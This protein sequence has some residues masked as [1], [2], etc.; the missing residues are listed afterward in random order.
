MV[1]ELDVR[2]TSGA[3]VVSPA[4][5]QWRL[6]I[7]G[8]QGGGYRLAQLDD[9]ST[10]PRTRFRWYPPVSLELRARVSA[11]DLPGTW[12]FGLWNDPFTASLGMAGTARRLP[13]LPEAAWFFCAS[14][15]NYLALHDTHP[16]QGLLAATFA[17]RRISAPLLAVALPALP[18]LAWSLTAR[19]L[20]MAARRFVVEDALLLDL[21]P[22][23]WH[24]YR[25]DW[26]RDAVSFAVDGE[27][28]FS[29]P[30]APRAPLGLVLWIDNQYAAFPPDGRLRFG[31]LPNPLAWLELADL[32]IQ[33]TFP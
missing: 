16:A 26:C 1:P 20:R 4:S 33:K 12:G 30:V 8:G 19:W 24:S 9:Y 32:T 29:T 15:P 23:Q 14:P 25:L 11:V 7:P 18:L 17:S 10:L 31:T 5:G 2:T 6:C 22:T 27:P 21:D 13:A 28:C 3:E